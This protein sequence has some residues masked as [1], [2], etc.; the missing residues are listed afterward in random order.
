MLKNFRLMKC[1]AWN[2]WPLDSCRCL[3]VPRQG[4]PVFRRGW[5][6]FWEDQRCSENREH[7]FSP[8]NH[9]LILFP[10]HTL[11]TEHLAPGEVVGSA[12]AGG[13]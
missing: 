8:Q 5:A 12:V 2:L 11:E 3:I 4:A 10:E 1:N 13:L 9:C 6:V 7:G